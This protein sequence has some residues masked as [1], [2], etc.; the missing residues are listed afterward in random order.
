MV[1]FNDVFLSLLSNLRREEPTRLEALR[2]LIEH[3][4]GPQLNP[5][6]MIFPAADRRALRHRTWSSRLIAW[7]L[8][9][10]N[11]ER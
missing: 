8:R 1:K 7:R 9:K 3:A 2:G 6:R 5:P 4:D 10:H 11:A